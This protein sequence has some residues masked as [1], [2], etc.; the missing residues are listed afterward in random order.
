[1]I[2][3]T[4]RSKTIAKKK[5]ANVTRPF[6]REAIILAYKKRDFSFLTVHP[7]HNQ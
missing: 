5:R 2:G 4:E 6:G 3:K 1:M 7:L